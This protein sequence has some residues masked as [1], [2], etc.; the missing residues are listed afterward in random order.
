MGFKPVS[1]NDIDKHFREYPKR[2]TKVTYI[3]LVE[4]VLSYQFPYDQ[5]L[6]GKPIVGLSVRVNGGEADRRSLSGAALAAIDVLVNGFITIA[7]GSDNTVQQEPLENYLF[8]FNSETGGKVNPYVQLCLPPGITLQNCQL[9]FSPNT[10]INTDE[11]VEFCWVY[12][13][14]EKTNPIWAS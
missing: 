1:L 14:P 5:F 11:V 8:T 2:W 9:N 3:Q 6:D 10:T 4:N 12:L 7:L 13:D